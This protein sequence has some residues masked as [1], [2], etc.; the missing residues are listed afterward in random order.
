VVINNVYHVG[1]KKSMTT[2]H[3]H[4]WIE[5]GNGYMCE[6]GEYCREMEYRTMKFKKR[7]PCGC[8]DKVHF[9]V[10]SYE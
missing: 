2:K 9:W 3:E 6:C 7:E 5:T 8:K 4:Q 1:E 10:D